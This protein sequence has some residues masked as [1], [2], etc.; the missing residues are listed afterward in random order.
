MLVLIVCVKH[1]HAVTES[2]A[3]TC[4]F[5]PLESFLT[6][7]N[8]IYTTSKEPEPCAI[9]G[10]ILKSERRQHMLPFTVLKIVDFLDNE[11]VRA[12]LTFP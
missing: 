12:Y 9:S 4:P 2:A 6:R 11:T 10:D 1:S 8:M 7:P 3:W 5:S